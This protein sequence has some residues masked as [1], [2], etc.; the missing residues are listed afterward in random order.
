MPR[1]ICEPLHYR[2]K[3]SVGGIPAHAREAEAVRIVVIEDL[4]EAC[5]NVIEVPF[6]VGPVGLR[7]GYLRGLRWA[8]RFRNDD[9]AGIMRRS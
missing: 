2:A 5:F 3:S 1:G 4:I 8:H 7:P 6:E 9:R